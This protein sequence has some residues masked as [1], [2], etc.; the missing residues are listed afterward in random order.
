M[1]NITYQQA[2]QRQYDVIIIGGG[3]AAGILTRALNG[4]GKRILVVEAGDGVVTDF[5]AHMHHV[6]QYMVANAK[7]PNAPFPNSNNAPQ[8][9]V[10]DVRQITPDHPDTTGYF[11]QTGPYP[12]ES[13][14]TRRLG[15]T[16]LHWF[17]S[18]PRMLP[19]DFEMQS[20]FGRGVDWPWSYDEL[21]PYYAMAEREIGVSANVEDQTYHGIHF[22]DDYVYPM[23][24]IPP[25]YLDQWFCK[26][27]D[28]MVDNDGDEPRQVMI[29]SIPQARNSTPN[30]EY[31]NG[32]GYEP[33]GAVGNPGIGKR[34]MGN[35]SCIPICPIQARFNILKSF[36]RSQGDVLHKAVATT[37]NIDSDTGRITGV[38]LKIWYDQSPEHINITLSAPTIVLAAN[39]IENAKL[40][41]ASGACKNN[42]AL[43]RNLMDHPAILSWGLAPED[44]GAFRGPGL[45]STLV[46]Y[47]GG[48]FRQDR[49][50]FVFEI[51]NWGW[52]WPKN[53]PI[54]TVE[55]QVD[56]ANAFGPSLRRNVHH[57]ISR[58]IRVDLM[59]EQLPMANN[60]VTIDPA[61]RDQLGNYRPILS[62]DV[63]Q[64]TQDG[65]VFGRAFTQ[66]VFERLGVSDHTA[67]STEDPGYFTNHGEG[68]AWSGVGHVAGT[69]RM[70]TCGSDAVVNR[71]QRAFDHDNLFIV[72][73]GSLPTLG[74]SNPTLTMAAL[75]FATAEHI[76]KGNH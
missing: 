27:L 53:E 13:T 74:T 20:R 39:A 73:C 49:A 24:R 59:T 21:L 47:R 35:S 52:Q 3:F 64:Y 9:L 56:R 28:G 50:A 51:G 65:M 29:R 61:Y 30:D 43:G 62:Y 46:T 40:L 48:A 14:Y 25:T 31:N 41:L 11:V 44:I 37:L 69:H 26:G 2:Q 19:E 54:G 67:Y 38:N 45:T 23:H 66:R 5:D 8:P 22:E 12:F 4:S 57:I 71:Y 33:V 18:C 1:K 15:G 6:E 16:S 32:E 58:Q 63:D 70:G 17:G 42:D 72:G 75:L 68:Y 10:T 36:E 7:I 34:C 60:R 55:D 76:L